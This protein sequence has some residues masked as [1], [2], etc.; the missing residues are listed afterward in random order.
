[1]KK[2]ELIKNAAERGINLSEE[3]A[4]KYTNL[5]DEEL[6]NISGG[7]NFVPCFYEPSIPAKQPCIR[8]H[9]TTNPV[10]ECEGCEHYKMG[11]T[12][13]NGRMEGAMHCFRNG[14]F[15]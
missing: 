7:A 11:Y 2:E 15:K 14:S 8:G 9:A 4:E 5:S 6:E 10:P 3:Q 12:M 13:S 1:M